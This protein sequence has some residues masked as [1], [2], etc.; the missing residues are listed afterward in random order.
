L[1][2]LASLAQRRQV[3]SYEEGLEQKRARYE[4]LSHVSGRS[5]EQHLEMA[6]CCLSL[7]ESGVFHKR[8][9]QHIR[10]ILKKIPSELNAYTRASSDALWTRLRNF[11]KEKNG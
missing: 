6:D 2:D 4:E 5:I 3:V 7:V 11:E 1:Q 9:L 10:M 8:Q